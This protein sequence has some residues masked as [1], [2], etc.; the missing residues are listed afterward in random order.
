M[1]RIL[2]VHLSRRPERKAVDNLELRLRRCSGQ[3]CAIDRVRAN[4]ASAPG[5]VECNGI[6]GIG[7][8]GDRRA[9]LVP[10]I[11]PAA[12]SRRMYRERHV[13]NALRSIGWTHT[14]RQRAARARGNRRSRR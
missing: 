8:A 14:D 7:R 3:P 9:V 13:R 10:L 11:R 2:G 4:P 1:S 12:S 6:T 5:R